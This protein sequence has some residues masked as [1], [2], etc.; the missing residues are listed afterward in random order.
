VVPG[1]PL[2]DFKLLVRTVE[3]LVRA[4]ALR[5]A[6]SGVDVSFGSKSNE[7]KVTVSA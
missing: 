5:T 3:T 4:N 6:G 2:D 1:N 7:A